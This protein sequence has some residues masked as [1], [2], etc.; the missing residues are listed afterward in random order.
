M[1][2]VRRS[3]LL[4]YSTT[5][6]F[7]LVNDVERYPE[8]LPWC[9]EAKIVEGEER[10][11]IAELTIRKGGLGERFTTRNVL[12]RPRSIVLELVQGP[13]KSLTGAW[14]FTELSDLGSKVELELDFEMTASLIHKTLGVLF[15]HAAG[16]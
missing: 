2:T 13:F 7:D 11:I 8:F 3:A 12:D 6:I 16:T 5:Q 15:A 14:R 1:P 10:Q 4:P 9:S